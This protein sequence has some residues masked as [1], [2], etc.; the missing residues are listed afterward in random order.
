MFTVSDRLCQRLAGAQT[1]KGHAFYFPAFFAKKTVNRFLGPK[2]HAA[3]QTFL[4]QVANGKVHLSVKQV[5]MIN[6]LL[7]IC[8]FGYAVLVDPKAGCVCGSGEDVHIS[9]RLKN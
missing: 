9:V 6:L 4:L 1:K 5:K 8:I 7:R 3:D 2:W